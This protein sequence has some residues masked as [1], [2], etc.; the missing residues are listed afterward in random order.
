MMSKKT[1]TGL[2]GLLLAG[3]TL[4]AQ[5]GSVFTN[6]FARIAT[7]EKSWYINTAGEKVFDKIESSFPPVDS[8]SNEHIFS[9]NTHSMMIVRNNGKYGL[10]DDRGKWVLKPEYDK[11]ELQNNI[12]LNLYKQGKMTYAD[13]WGKLLLPLQFEK[14]G[15]LDDHRF[16]VKQQGKWGIY[17][18]TQGKLV[19]P[20][21]YDEFDYCGGCGLKSD[22]VYA[23][24]GGKWGIV[25]SSGEV[26]IPFAFEHKHSMMRSDEWVCSFTQQ[27]KEVVVNIP[28][29][30][31]YAAPTY[32]QMEVIG[33]G[34]LKAKKNGR[35]GLINVKG[36]QVLDFIYDNIEDPYG[37]Y[38]SGPY[39]TV[40]KG[41]KTGIVTASGKVVVAPSLDEDV[42]CSDDYIIA[43][44]DGMY[45]IYDS[46]GKPLL[47]Q[48][49]NGIELMS[50]SGNIPLFALKR[51]ALYGFVNLS[52]GKVVTPAFHEVGMVTYG[53]DKGLV[54]V[55][56][57]G[58]SGL[59]K[60][61]GTL[62][63][64]P[65][66][67]G[68][69]LLSD[70]LLTFNT[71]TGTGLFNT[72]AQQE[73][74]PAKFKYIDPLAP[75][76]TLLSVTAVTA[77]GEDV[78]GLYSLTGKELIPPVYTSLL[79]MNKDQYLVMKDNGNAVYSLSTGKMTPLPY[80]SVAPAHVPDLLIVSD[81]K[82]S[83]LWNVAKGKVVS[84][85]YPMVKRYEGDTTLS[86]SIPEFAFGVAPVQQNGKMGAIN[87][88][89]EEVLPFI[90]DGASMLK[91]GVILLI[92][93]SGENWK[94]GYADTT[95]KL[96]VPLDYDYNADGYPYDYDDSEYLSL[97]KLSDGLSRTHSLSYKKGLADRSGKVVIPPLYNEVFIG[98][99]N[100][101]FVTKT[102]QTVTVLD[103]SGK[104]ITAEKFTA[105]MLDRLASPYS[106]GITL[107][108][109]LLCRKGEGYV[110][111]LADGKT[112][113]LR[114][115][116]VTSFNNEA[117]W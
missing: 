110:Y 15:I 115:T 59:Y 12:Y 69:Q 31:V 17:D 78:F 56:Y 88:R 1:M 95:G 32:S 64:P 109:P 82:N 46:T 35:F 89:G 27:G 55:S 72:R 104:A 107:T 116:D 80:S 74:I 10:V 18:A 117:T 28:L 53:K 85:P 83:F 22:Y 23:K 33:E 87:S 38:A 52:N 21:I 5:Q 98:N 24:K 37:S 11:L 93:K 25:S 73:I 6:G 61:D 71:A 113:P 63:L 39:L 34:V 68:Y 66:Y 86:P 108:Y 57:Q 13:T 99:K 26:L 54:Q 67:R 62:L 47:Q 41:G 44:H 8:I 81:G 75:D 60:P 29:K 50:S 111:L 84:K 9:S 94:Y 51:Q 102:E 7:K 96:L 43:A 97:F 112:L 4:L 42:I 16:D 70:T 76:S 14:V 58:Q 106:E 65:K 100:S 101:G 77:A 48:N 105:V 36:E 3:H 91:Q 20:A 92:R 114:I 40:T 30:K 45:N 79:P 49:Y 90:Y 19:I 2:L 103:A